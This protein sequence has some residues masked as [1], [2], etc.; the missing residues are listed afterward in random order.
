[1]LLQELTWG[2]LK[3]L[4]HTVRGAAAKNTVMG[5]ITRRAIKSSLDDGNPVFADELRCSGR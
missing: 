4:L 5:E 1:M 2:E 3:N